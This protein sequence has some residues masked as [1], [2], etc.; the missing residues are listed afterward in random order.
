MLTNARRHKRKECDVIHS[1]LLPKLTGYIDGSWGPSEADATLKVHNPATGEL[2][3]E[4]PDMAAKETRAA[5]EAAVRA[6]ETQADLAQRQ[7][8]LAEIA[9]LIEENKKELGR[10]V[11]LENGKP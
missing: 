4:V 2:L 3:A 7:T 5:I 10:I 8:W 1:E 6:Q 9:R 11:T